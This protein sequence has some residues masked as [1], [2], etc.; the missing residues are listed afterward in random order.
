M[1]NK[2]FSPDVLTLGLKRELVKDV[3]PKPAVSLI[4]RAVEE[5]HERQGIKAPADEKKKEME[6]IKRTTVDIPVSLH[7]LICKHLVDKDQTLRD[8]FL[9]L[10]RKDLGIEVN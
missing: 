7:K 6:P 4:E 8:Y 1:K 5:I 9:E 2:K 3:N 10:A